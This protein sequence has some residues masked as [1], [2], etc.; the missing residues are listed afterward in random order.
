MRHQQEIYYRSEA[1]FLQGVGRGWRWAWHPWTGRCMQ[2]SHWADTQQFWTFD[3]KLGLF[4]FCLFFPGSFFNF[5]LL[6]Q[7]YNNFP[8][9]PL[10]KAPEMLLLDCSP[11]RP[12]QLLPCVPFLQELLPDSLR[13]KDKTIRRQVF[14]VGAQWEVRHNHNMSCLE[15]SCPFQVL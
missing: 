3:N 14:L 1:A 7:L 2:T 5:S 11:P 9:A 15:A 12:L 4:V 10:L 13:A 6:A 8:G